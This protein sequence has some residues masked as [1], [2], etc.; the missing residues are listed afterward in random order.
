MHFSTQESEWYANTLAGLNLTP[1]PA[2]IDLGPG[3]VTYDSAV[4]SDESRVRP[5]TDEE[6][7]RALALGLLNNSAYRYPLDRMYIERYYTIGRP[8]T[9]RAEVDLILYDPDGLP[10][11]MWELKAPDAYDTDMAPSI[12]DQLFRTAPQLGEPSLL[13]FATIDPSAPASFRCLVIDYTQHKDYDSWVAAGSPAA[14]H[15][16]PDY[17]LPQYPLNRP[18]FP[19]GSNL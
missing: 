4:R 17:Q 5:V 1:P 12:R 2:I 7:V 18:G 10:F 19:G 8:S 14:N 15:V 9:S 6:L 13:V 16:P 11:A 3:L